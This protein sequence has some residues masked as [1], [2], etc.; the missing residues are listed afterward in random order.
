MY[1]QSIIPT[2][3][4]IE[5]GNYLGHTQQ[6]LLWT[7]T[8]ISKHFCLPVHNV[9]FRLVRKF[10]FEIFGVGH[11]V[12]AA[13]YSLCNLYLYKYKNTVCDICH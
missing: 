8:E 13:Q 10:S 5:R 2:S 11:T 7:N 12:K 3:N 6:L 1:I 9:H 4:H